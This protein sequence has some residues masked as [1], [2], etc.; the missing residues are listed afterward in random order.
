MEVS[1]SEPMVRPWKEPSAATRWVRPVRRVSL[2]AASLAS[3]PEL[4][5]NTR[6]GLPSDAATEQ[7]L[8]QLDLGLC[9]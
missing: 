4:V 2:K 1:A 5:K 8:G 6:P 9:W 3:V 7:P